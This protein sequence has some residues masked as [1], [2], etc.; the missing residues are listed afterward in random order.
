M[1]L[2]C[3]LQKDAKNLISLVQKLDTLPISSFKGATCSYTPVIHL[4]IYLKQCHF[5]ILWSI[6]LKIVANY[7]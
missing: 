6:L 7:A 4:S 1:Q 5:I 2:Q 3:R